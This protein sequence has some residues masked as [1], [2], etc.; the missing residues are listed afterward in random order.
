MTSHPQRFPFLA[1]AV[2]RLRRQTLQPSLIA[3]NI[4]KESVGDLPKLDPPPGVPLEVFPIEDIGPGSKLIPT[5]SRNPLETVVTL[6]DD[7]IYRSDLLETLASHQARYPTAVIAG[8]ARLIP[9]FPFS[10]LVPYTLWPFAQDSGSS[11]RNELLLPLG[12]E[13][14][15]YPPHSL[16]PGVGNVDLLKKTALRT[17]DLWFWAHRVKAGSPL[18]CLPIQPMQPRAPGSAE[19][20]LWKDNK[21]GPNRQTMNALMRIITDEASQRLESNLLEWARLEGGVL[22]SELARSVKRRM[23]PTHAH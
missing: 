15:L 12:A 3:V 6:D 10:R 23:A 7:V 14:V 22:A 5:L 21:A 8:L 17:D 4:A 1:D 16:H 19:S 18:R 13:G 9:L 2:R 20:G 11:P